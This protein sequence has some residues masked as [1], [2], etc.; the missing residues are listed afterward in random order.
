MILNII[1]AIINNCLMESEKNTIILTLVYQDEEYRVQTR[2]N[3]YHSLMTL[4]SEHL[5]I[6]GFGLC[7]G[8]ASCGTCMVEICE[9]NAL[10]KQSVLA[11]DVQV[12][13]YI[14]NA[15]I[16]IPRY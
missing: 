4:I 6:I 15:I 1:K 14:A 2:R 13:D 8:M 10:T 12:N 9:K 7:C 5:P 3:E 16:T 11:C